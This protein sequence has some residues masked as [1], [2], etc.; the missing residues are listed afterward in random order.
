MKLRLCQ[1]GEEEEEWMNKVN[2]IFIY[3]TTDKNGGETLR[4]WFTSELLEP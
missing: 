2:N 3:K 4:H 1:G